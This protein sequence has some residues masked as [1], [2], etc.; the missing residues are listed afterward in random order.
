MGSCPCGPVEGDECQGCSA[1]QCVH[2]E[3]HHAAVAGVEDLLYQG[4]VLPAHPPLYLQQ[5][6]VHPGLVLH[7]PDIR[8]HNI[9]F[10]LGNCE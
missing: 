6:G 8:H 7:T 4:E 2:V 9:Q 5:V 1:V 3:S 10:P